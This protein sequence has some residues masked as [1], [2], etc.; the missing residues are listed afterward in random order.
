[1]TQSSIC[2]GVAD[3]NGALSWARKGSILGNHIR[4]DVVRFIF[5]KIEG[6]PKF[7]MSHHSLSH[8]KESIALS[9]FKPSIK[10]KVPKFRAMLKP[11]PV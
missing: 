3:G 6:H 5:L 4:E 11:S 8:H 9:L 2:I 7:P 1:M 10:G